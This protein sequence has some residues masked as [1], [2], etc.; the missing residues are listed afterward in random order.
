MGLRMVLTGGGTGGHVYPAL[1]VAEK[2]QQDPDV[3]Q[4]LYIGK[5]DSLESEL[6][7]KHGFAFEG[8]SFYGMPRGKSPLLLFKM[9]KWWLDL[10]K[11]IRKA[12]VLLEGFRPHVVLGTGGYVS[13][14]VLMAARQLKIP[15]VVHEPDACPGLVN[16]TMAKNASAVTVAF[17][18]AREKLRPDP[19]KTYFQVT[20]NPIR[21]EIG[22]LDKTEALARLGLPWDE[23]KPV[24]VVI[25]GS[26]GARTLNRAI[27]E[28]LPDLID[29]LDIRVLHQTGQKL[30]EETLDQVPEAF[31]DH[32]DY[33]I[34][35]Y[36]GD[37]PAVWSAADV[38][39]C[40]AGSL[41]LSELYLSGTPSVL[42]PYPF[43]AAD[44]QRKNAEASRR[45]G[46]SL[47]LEDTACK[48][49]AI[50]EI[51]A[52]LFAEPAKRQAMS[53]KAAA[54]AHPD[55]TGQIVALLKRAAGT[56]PPL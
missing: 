18:E 25:G 27:V 28:A 31:L 29:Q 53:G 7:P 21:G 48:A 19:R 5:T 46:A 52:P 47:T 13:A 2:L 20:G 55:A 43:A 45:A 51:L 56:G 49:P 50:V 44:H 12:R 42:V 10:Q 16:R 32:P 36:Y 23:G 33:C 24:L 15:Y 35:P 17:V 11:A 4:L 30:Y 38:A 26:Q 14:P 6:I 39:L 41:T 22:H 1:A 9:L 54:L 8:I 3:E 40:R 34:R 37:M